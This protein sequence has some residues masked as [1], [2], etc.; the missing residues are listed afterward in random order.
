MGFDINNRLRDLKSIYDEKIDVLIHSDI[1]DELVN[2]IIYI[3]SEIFRIKKNDQIELND[4]WSYSAFIMN[5]VA[6]R[7]STESDKYETIAQKI[8]L[9]STKYCLENEAKSNAL[10]F[11][12]HLKPDSFEMFE[13]MIDLIGGELKH[14]YVN[15]FYSNKIIIFLNNEF[16]K[17]GIYPTQIM[18]LNDYLHTAMSNMILVLTKIFST[19]NTKKGT[20][21]SLDY[22]QWFIFI[23]T[24]NKEIMKEIINK[25]YKDSL[26]KCKQKLEPFIMVR[27]SYIAHYDINVIDIIK[28]YRISIQ[29]IKSIFNVAVQL[30][31]KISLY[32][33]HFMDTAYHNM[34]KYNGFKSAVCQN[35]FL[36]KGIPDIEFYFNTL[37]K[38]FIHRS[39]EK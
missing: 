33:Y 16:A 19:S 27:N 25:E 20:N 8:D 28:D 10:Y 13:K 36:D 22:L 4:H 5:T 39:G 9:L 32:K 14:L 1:E 3:V 37:R 18:F 26:K 2:N 17:N 34:I 29:E 30:F 38:D 35:L 23:N 11:K 7:I 21:F 24:C 12:N 15:I 31:E 6:K